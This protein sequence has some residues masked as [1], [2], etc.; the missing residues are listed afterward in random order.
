MDKKNITR[1]LE[2]IVRDLKEVNLH[3]KGNYPVLEPE[4]SC[5]RFNL[6][7]QLVWKRFL[8]TGYD[9]AFLVKNLDDNELE[10]LL[11]LLL[12]NKVITQ[13]IYDY[14]IG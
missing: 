4:D 3:D 13:N 6:D 8:G 10:I 2:N 1:V 12:D 7:G 14:L 5:L 9:E 11:D